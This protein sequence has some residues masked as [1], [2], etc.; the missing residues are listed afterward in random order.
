MCVFLKLTNT[1]TL[2][3]HNDRPNNYKLRTKSICVKFS[4]DCQYQFFQSR[5]PGS[6]LLY[7]PARVSDWIEGF[8]QNFKQTFKMAPEASPGVTASFMYILIFK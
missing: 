6:F 7:P 4:T 8:V 2:A 1:N 5:L 3:V